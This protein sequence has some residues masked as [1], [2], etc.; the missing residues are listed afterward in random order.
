[1]EE[2]VF[3]KYESRSPFLKLPEKGSIVIARAA[4]IICAGLLLTLGI[5]EL[6]CIGIILIQVM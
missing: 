5:I 6:V 4:F 3:D 1:M 2:N